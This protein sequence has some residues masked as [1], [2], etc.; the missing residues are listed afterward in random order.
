MI[1]N[2]IHFNKQIFQLYHNLVPYIINDT[3]KIIHLYS[4]LAIW[5]LFS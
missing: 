2:D 3:H 1:R 4:V 5:I